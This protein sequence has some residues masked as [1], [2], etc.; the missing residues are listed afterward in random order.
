MPC[1]CVPSARHERGRESIHI[2]L[3]MS[4]K[5]AAAR[6]WFSLR[7]TNGLLW[8]PMHH[9]QKNTQNTCILVL[10]SWSNLQAALSFTQAEIEQF[11][12]GTSPQF[13][14]CKG[15]GWETCLVFLIIN[16]MFYRV[17]KDF[18]DGWERSK[19]EKK[20]SNFLLKKGKEKAPE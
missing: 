13:S 10:C 14:K 4:L 15:N 7:A 8:I 18:C 2:C 3:W 19:E 12:W 9:L 11:L 6:M 5:L 17:C 20:F 1:L 16:D